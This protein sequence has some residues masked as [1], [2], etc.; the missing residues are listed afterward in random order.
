MST[1][2]SAT[3]YYQLNKGKVLEYK[4]QFYYNKTKKHSIFK[5]IKIKGFTKRES[6]SLIKTAIDNNNLLI[7][8]NECEQIELTDFHESYE[9]KSFSII[10][11]IANDDSDSSR[12]EC[13]NIPYY[14]IKQYYNEKDCNHK[15]VLSIWDN[16][17]QKKLK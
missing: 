6:Q 10:E 5:N 12:C 3:K 2:S 16:M 1:L 11:I 17:L 13:Q 4:K 7:E 8:L 9:F 14:D 15:L